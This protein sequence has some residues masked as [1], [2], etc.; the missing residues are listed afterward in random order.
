M[1]VLSISFGPIIIKMSENTESCQPL[2][3]DGKNLLN[4]LNITLFSFGQNPS[5]YSI[6]SF[7]D[8]GYSMEIGPLH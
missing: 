8:T 4:W 2:L 6:F 1:P 3:F 5:I 7:G